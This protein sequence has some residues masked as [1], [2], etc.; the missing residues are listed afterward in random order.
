M[1]VASGAYYAPF[2]G[3]ERGKR[4][5][6]GRNPHA[7]SEMRFTGSYTLFR[8]KWGIKRRTDGPREKRANFEGLKGGTLLYAPLPTSLAA[9]T[10]KA[11]PY[12]RGSLRM[13]RPCPDSV[14][15]TS[16][17]PQGAALPDVPPMHYILTPISPMLKPCLIRAA[18]WGNAI[19]CAEIGFSSERNRF[20][21]AYGPQNIVCPGAE[22]TCG[23]DVGVVEF[24]CAV[25]GHIRL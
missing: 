7:R 22:C 3:S 16:R 14:T 12:P 25:I 4:A 19:S 13:S 21:A 6:S 17:N 20:A 2:G 10:W 11:S 24:R 23:I 15:V 1:S 5:W 8:Y 18:P 9:K